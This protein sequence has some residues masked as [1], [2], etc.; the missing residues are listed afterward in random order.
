MGI[1][2]SNDPDMTHGGAKKRLKRRDGITSMDHI[3]DSAEKQNSNEDR[4]VRVCLLG[5]STS[6]KSS[7]LEKYLNRSGEDSDDKDVKS[8]CKSTVQSSQKP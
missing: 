6:G 4:N 3:K 1:C 5:D 8:V 7:L 2:Q